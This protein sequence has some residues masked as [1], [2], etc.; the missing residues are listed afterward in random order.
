MDIQIMAG[1]LWRLRVLRQRDRW[2]RQELEAYQATALRRLRDYAYANSPFYRQFHQGMAGRPLHELPVLT[3]AMVMEHFD[4]LVTDRAIHLK[5]VE[6]HLAQ[7]QD[8]GQFLG[9]Y[10]VNTTSGSTGRRGIFL[11]N[12]SEWTSVLASFARAHEWAGAEISLS[13][14][15]KMASV[16]STTP[17]HM[18]ARVAATLRSRW[19]P[20]LRLAASEPVESIVLQLNEWQ[21]DMLVSYASMARILADEQSAGRL[22]IHPHLVFTSSEV[23]TEETRRRAE[24]AWNQRLF[25]QYATTE[26]AGL[27]AECLEH[28]GLHL[29]EDLV[30]AEVVDKD[31][32][33]VSPGVFGDKVLVTVLF[34]RTQPLIRYELSDS[35]QMAPQ[36]C[37]C[38]RPHALVGGI[39]G[40]MEDVLRLPAAAGG[41]VAVQPLVFHRVMDAVPAGGWQVMQDAGGL[42]VL[43]SG[44]RQGFE[45]ATIAVQLR[46]ALAAQ[47]AVPPA[48]QVERVAA[49][50]QTAAGKAPLIKRNVRAG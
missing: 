35:V 45:D 40:R 16:A 26:T 47:G 48:I 49:I 3:K 19:M 43:L 22:H 13:H 33:P 39:Q 44:V 7:L 46:D 38:G 10:W 42:H 20:A 30:I 32:R 25:N 9:R 8:D 15:M 50:P 18:S 36:A 2:T 14:S 1:L 12:R 28:A 23:L 37:P 34:N 41:E 11:F 21:P 24:Q 27:A 29:L 17:W 31:N 5:D 4:D 6:T